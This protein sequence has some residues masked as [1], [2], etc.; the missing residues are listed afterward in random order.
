MN[1]LKIYTSSRINEEETD[2]PFIRF[3]YDYSEGDPDYDDDATPFTYIYDDDDLFYDPETQTEREPETEEEQAQMEKEFSE[4]VQF[5]FGW[6]AA[7]KKDHPGED[8]S[9]DGDYGSGPNAD[10]PE[11]QKGY[12]YYHIEDGDLPF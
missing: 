1:Y 2:P 6:M 10:S 9:Y 7:W 4:N 5:I 11:W 8:W 12:Q 3:D